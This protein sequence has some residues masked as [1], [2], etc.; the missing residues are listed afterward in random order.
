MQDLTII[1]ASIWDGVE[2]APYRGSVHVKNGRIAKVTHENVQ[3][4]VNDFSGKVIDAE[5]G[6][7][8]PAFTDVHVHCSAYARHKFGINISKTQS[9]EEAL[10]LIQEKGRNLGI[11]E[12]IYVTGL[13]ENNWSP[14][15]LP[16]ADDFHGV[17][18]PL[19]VMRICTHIHV[20]NRR[21]L[22]E[23][24]V[25]NLEGVEGVCRD[26]AGRPNGILEENAAEAVNNIYAHHLKDSG[27][28][29]A[30][31]Q[32]TFADFLSVGIGEIHPVGSEGI[33]LGEDMGDYNAFFTKERLP[34][35]TVFYFDK[36]PAIPIPSGFGNRWIAYGGLKL[37]LDGS[38]GGRTAALNAPYDDGE[39]KGTLLYSH[40]ELEQI[41][42][43]AAGRNLQVMTHVIGDRAIDQLLDV[44]ET[45][46][47]KN[48]C[49]KYPFKAAHMEVCSP[50]NVAR[51]GK[52]GLFCDM[53][54]HQICSDAFMAP[55]RLGRRSAW[56]FPVK[57]LMESGATICCSCDA[58]CEPL[59]PLAGVRAAI[60]RQNDEYFPKGGWN[61]SEGISLSAALSTYTLNPQRLILRDNWKGT[62]TVGKVADIAIYRRN[63]FQV[64][65]D[66][67]KNITPEWTIVDGCIRWSKNEGLFP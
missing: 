56:C 52:L 3:R 55:A 29:S 53:Q 36:F 34:L 25:H 57:S 39:G 60:L 40:K 62:L 31:L 59:N 32:E 33:G 64:E 45:L 18:Q 16:V 37:F 38:L 61:L 27:R 15:I 65:V 4:C 23:I 24:G 50:E 8:L 19:L 63:I 17:E 11:D 28:F 35:R 54:F 48:I 14:S 44:L 47:E 66:E 22:K 10:A 26:D 46:R 13:N 1:N 12:W 67:L 49:W 7:V 9:F 42:T 30:A 21:A 6:T 43:E 5:G 2:D 20:V 58:P 51:I 41:L